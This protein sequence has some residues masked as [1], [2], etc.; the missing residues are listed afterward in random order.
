MRRMTK[1]VRWLALAAGFVVSAAAPARAQF[2]CANCSTEISSL[3]GIAKQAMQYG[4]QIQQYQNELQRYALMVTNTVALPQQ[5]WENVQSDIMQ[6]RALANASSLLT[7]NAG[8]L[9]SRL[10]NGQGFITQAG[11][12]TQ[13]AGQMQQWQQT[14]GNS[15][16]SLGRALGVQQ[17]QEQNN[18]ALLASLQMH[19]QTAT[20][21]MQAIQA[22][23]EIAGQTAAQLQQVEATLQVMAQTQATG[24]VVDAN[25]RAQEDAAWLA[26]NGGPV[27]ATTGGK[28]W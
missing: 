27:L 22:G 7:G 1:T 6:V 8:S 25:R 9:V 21:Q 16:N 12:L 3:M 26:F 18:A 11:N 5:L 17:G 2:V 13:I 15:A 14:I 4:T 10:Q 19:S 24:M 20:G 23:N 28:S